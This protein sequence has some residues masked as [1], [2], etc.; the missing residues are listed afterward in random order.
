[1]KMKR[2]YTS[3]R[4]RYR[5]A[6]RNAKTHEKVQ[7]HRINGPE[8]KEGLHK[9]ELS[10]KQEHMEA[11]NK[12]KAQIANKANKRRLAELNSKASS[13][14]ELKKNKAILKEMH[15]KRRQALLKIERK[16]KSEENAEKT[17]ERGE[18]EKVNKVEK[19][20]KDK[21]KAAKKIAKEQMFKDGQSSVLKQA[22]EKRNKRGPAKERKLKKKRIQK[23]KMKMKRKYTSFRDRYRL[24]FRNAKTHEKVQ[25]HRINGPELKEGLHKGE[26]SQKQ[27]QL[28]TKT[29]GQ[30]QALQKMK[31]VETAADVNF[32]SSQ[33]KDKY[34]KA[35]IVNAER[36]EAKTK[37]KKT[38]DLKEAA[39]ASTE[40]A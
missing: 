15:T 4:D 19:E 14:E 34:A 31:L 10:Q 12:L 23:M 26:L 21:E 24:A 18:K 27:E 2:K 3:F 33:V 22:Q 8:L 16:T 32:K 13:K 40:R 28:V 29:H 7:K 1:M 20:K 38:A 17:A 25:K 39:E 11:S 5:L 6:F 9:G 35:G 37:L 36:N 30:K